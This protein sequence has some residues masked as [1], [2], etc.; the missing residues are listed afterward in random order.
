[1]S[2]ILNWCIEGLKKFYTNGLKPTVAIIEATAEYRQE[3]DKVGKFLNECLEPAKDNITAKTAYEVYEQWCRACG[4]GCENQGN[5]YAEL[6]SKNLISK[7]GTVNGVTK[8]RV[9]KGYKVTQEWIQ[10]VPLI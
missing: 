7:S 10:A 8:K 1:M 4:Y 6:R 9:L 5:F 2:G 3:S